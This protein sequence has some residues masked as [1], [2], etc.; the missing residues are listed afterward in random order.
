M[1]RVIPSTLGDDTPTAYTV[2]ELLP[3]NPERGVRLFRYVYVPLTRIDPEPA[4]P[5]SESASEA[6]P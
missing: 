2:E 5:T 1:I 4:E 3:C 6:R